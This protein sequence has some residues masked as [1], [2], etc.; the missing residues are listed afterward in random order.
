MSLNLIIEGGG[1]EKITYDSSLPTGMQLEEEIMSYLPISPSLE[2][3]LVT[4]GT[5][6]TIHPTGLKLENNM[7]VV[8]RL[9]GIH[10]MHLPSMTFMPCQS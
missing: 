3:G 4:K 8:I 2:I 5:H 9:L 10:A 1:L 7:V 6:D